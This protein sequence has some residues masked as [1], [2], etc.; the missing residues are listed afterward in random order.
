MTD[1]LPEGFPLVELHCHLEGTVAPDFAL[2]LA[3]RHGLDLSGLIDDKGRYR[4]RNFSEFLAA[5]DRM[6]EAIL[7]PEDYADLTE[8]Y[9]R[10]M[11]RKGLVY[12]EAF[13]SPDHA[14]RHGMRYRT[15][16]DAVA[17]GAARV[18]ADHD[19]AIRFIL[20][21]VRHYGVEAAESVARLAHEE[22]HPRVTG[23][24][25]GGDEN[26]LLPRDFARAFAI[27]R[28]AGL[29][30]T[31]HAGEVMGPESVRA[32]IEDL[33]ISR[34]GHGV[35]AIEDPSVLA[36]IRDRG[37]V[38][39]VCPGSNIALGIY[40]DRRSHPLRRLI[41]AGVRVT[42]SSDD[43]P[44]FATDIAREYE[45]ARTV[46]GLSEADMRKI[47]ETA[48]ESAFCDEPTRE[49]SRKSLIR[50]ENTPGS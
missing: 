28:D 34:I 39:E 19:I 6:T 26:H 14:L 48:L 49:R 13:L 36:L 29:G 45:A 44:F 38:L 12:A 18:E 10:A 23:F 21:A 31:C 46:H 42:L 3:A 11:A 30:L 25:M 27:A 47:S 16:L 1:A 41:D 24:G 17:E 7:T 8:R 9:Y 35:R 32:A 15:M 2:R 4:W 33:G 40:P 37:I 20:I 43:P 22:P 50:S 5:Y